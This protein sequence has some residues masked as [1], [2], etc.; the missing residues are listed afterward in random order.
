MVE[1]ECR[2][3]SI[4]NSCRCTRFL[5]SEFHEREKDSMMLKRALVMALL[6]GGL[7]WCD[8]SEAQAWGRYRRYGV[9][10]PVVVR[11]VMPAYPVTR[12]VVA[13]PYI[14]AY[15]AYPVYVA[16]VYVDPVYVAPI[17]GPGVSVSIGY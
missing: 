16:P 10:R 14:R 13:R 15:G 17:Y 5:L 7:A 3:S 1:H 4:W 2:Q 8:A 9:R 6:I 12:R 11:A